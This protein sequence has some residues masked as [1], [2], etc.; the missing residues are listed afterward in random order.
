MPVLSRSSDQDGAYRPGKSPQ[1][2]REVVSRPGRVRCFQGICLWLSILRRQCDKQFR[3]RANGPP[4]RV[5]QQI[6]RPRRGGEWGDATASAQLPSMRYGSQCGQRVWLDAFVSC[7]TCP[8]GNHA[9]QKVGKFANMRRHRRLKRS[10]RTGLQSCQQK[11]D[12]LKKL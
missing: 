5:R 7:I 10:S 8:R 11:N 12:T 9:T 2:M 6:L 4:N 3:D 1:C